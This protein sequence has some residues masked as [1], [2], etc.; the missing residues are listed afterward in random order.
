MCHMKVYKMV[1]GVE[2]LVADLT[3]WRNALRSFNNQKSAK[4]SLTNM[5]TQKKA[6]LETT[7]IDLKA[8]KDEIEE[9]E[10]QKREKVR[11]ET[12]NLEKEKNNKAEIDELKKKEDIEKITKISS[13][14]IKAAGDCS[15]E[16]QV[17]V[18]NALLANINSSNNTN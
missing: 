3:S 18:M 8:A 16:F 13:A 11:S 12:L 7:E 14:I 17:A 5:E 2:K 15:I 9:L 4:K 1:D 6:N 10:Y